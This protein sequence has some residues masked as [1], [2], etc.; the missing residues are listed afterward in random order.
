MNREFHSKQGSSA[1]R[2]IYAIGAVSGTCH[3]Q[4]CKVL[5]ASL[6]LGSGGSGGIFDLSLF[7]G[8]ML[9]TA[10]GSVFGSL[11]PSITAPAG[12]YGIVG[13]AAVFAGAA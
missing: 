7:I 11:F 1:L 9:G 13:V 4:V 3:I 6:T 8:A 10:V 2:F 12:A 5:A